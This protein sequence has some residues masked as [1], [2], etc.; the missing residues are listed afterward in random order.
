VRPPVDILQA[1]RAAPD[2]AA[3][4]EALRDI[5]DVW[6][7]GGAVRDVLLGGVPRELDI[8]V[9]GDP[10]AALAALGGIS[11]RYDRFGTATVTPEGGTRSHDVVRARR[12]RY[13]HPGALPEV[14]PAGID[15][16]LLRR[17]FTVNATAL[18]VTGGE[19][20]LR[21]VPG[22][23][24]DLAAGVVRVLHDASFLDDPTRLWR[25]ARYATRL[26]FA[27]DPHTAALAA[28]ADPATVSGPRL[29][30]ELRHALREPEPLAVLRAARG[31]NA[32][33]LPNTLTTEPPRLAA[34]L[35]LLPPD[36][37]PDLV[38]LAACA[39]PMAAGELV[40]WLDR[41]AFPAADREVVAAGSREMVRTP[42][43]VARTPA[44][45][46]RAARGVPVEI[47]ALAGGE[48]ARRWIDELR[49]VRLAVTGA[50]LLAAGVPQ[51][52]EIGRRLALAFDALLD[53]E[54]PDRDAQ[55]AVAL[56]GGRPG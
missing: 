7:V 54:A 21:A 14:E 19:P 51:G 1:L 55:L 30:N 37:R 24:D 33:L 40:A 15:E 3:L 2:A 28:A 12:E 13:P 22:A 46:G 20:E 25:A 38:T 17:D 32:A 27:V 10:A 6:V 26:G 48:G 35:D 5:P 4:L 41:L 45:I 16:D 34:A 11:V 29:G 8:V 31:L 39:E 56:A 49:H 43:R 9:E 47:V 42:L 18:R 44:E 36:G 53:G 50:D 52:P 23:L